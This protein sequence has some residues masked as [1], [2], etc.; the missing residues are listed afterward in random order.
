MSGFVGTDF[1]YSLGRKGSPTTWKLLAA[2]VA[3]VEI[4]LLN[5]ERVSG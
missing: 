1:N 4:H 3:A 2:D 5:Y